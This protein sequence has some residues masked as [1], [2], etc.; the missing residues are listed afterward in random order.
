MTLKKGKTAPLGG[1]PFF[2]NDLYAAIYIMLQQF[3]KRMGRKLCISTRR[4]RG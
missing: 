3:Y 1:F 2:S 4:R